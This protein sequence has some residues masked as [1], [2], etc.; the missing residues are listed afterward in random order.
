MSLIFLFYLRKFANSV[1]QDKVKCLIDNRK[2]LG[3]RARNRIRV[4][5]YFRYLGIAVSVCPRGCRGG[6][7]VTLNPMKASQASTHRGPVEPLLDRFA[8]LKQNTPVGSG[9]FTPVVTA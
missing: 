1:L 5:P 9:V 8:T 4:S 6:R 3:G 2:E 7:L